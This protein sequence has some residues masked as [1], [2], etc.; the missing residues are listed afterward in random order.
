[1]KYYF[2]LIL[3]FLSSLIFKQCYYSDD[4]EPWY[5]S[6]YPK[7]LGTISLN[8]SN[9][10]WISEKWA[11]TIELYNSTGLYNIFINQGISY[12]S[13][14][15]NFRYVTYYDGCGSADGYDYFY[16]EWERINYI[17]YDIPITIELMRR[18]R[19]PYGIDSISAVNAI[20]LLFV[21]ISGF[22]FEIPID[23]SREIKNSDYLDSLLIKDEWYYNIYHTYNDTI[24]SSST[25]N[26]VIGVFYN[27]KNGLLRF[28]LKNGEKWSLI[29]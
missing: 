14:K 1:M 26:K 20:D 17:S 23:S 12:G 22:K 27:F 13:D 5:K 16:S 11:E 9:N 29:Q 4:C 6:E 2:F 8:D 28:D 19:L 18:K 7:Y 10:H 3:I 21:N 15:F 25:S 24:I